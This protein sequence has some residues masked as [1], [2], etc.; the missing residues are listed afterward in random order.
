M[1]KLGLTAFAIWAAI[2]IGWV[3]NLIK[4]IGGVI[5]LAHMAD[6]S[7]ALVVRIIG[8][9]AFPLGALFGIFWW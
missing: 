5:A 6:I 1:F 2:I 4:A 7:G 3:I 9:F 8:I